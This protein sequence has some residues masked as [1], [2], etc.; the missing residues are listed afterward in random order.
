MKCPMPGCGCSV[1]M[2]TGIFEFHGA[3]VSKVH[4]TSNFGLVQP[5]LIF[6]CVFKVSSSDW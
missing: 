6:V 5:H 4:Q 2:A 1:C 3:P